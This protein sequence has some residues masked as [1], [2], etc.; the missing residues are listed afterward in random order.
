MILRRAPLRRRVQNACKTRDEAAQVPCPA[1]PMVWLDRFW[2]LFITSHPPP[3]AG[4]RRTASI[5]QLS[6]TR[7][8]LP[9]EP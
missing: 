4:S 5:T 2:P 1:Q 9:T 7:S 3:H 6:H 8:T